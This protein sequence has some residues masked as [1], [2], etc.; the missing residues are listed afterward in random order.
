MKLFLIAGA[1]YRLKYSELMYYRVLL[2]AALAE[3]I[4]LHK[5]FRLGPTNQKV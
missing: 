5:H 1:Q 2:L 3:A 4:T